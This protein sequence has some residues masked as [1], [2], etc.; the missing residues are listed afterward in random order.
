[1]TCVPIC[2]L[3]AATYFPFWYHCKGKQ[4]VFAKTA[5]PTG[6]PQAVV[7]YLYDV[8]LYPN[9]TIEQF[10]HLL[11]AIVESVCPQD[12]LDW[13]WCKQIT[14]LAAEINRLRKNKS[15]ILK[16]QI[17]IERRQIEAGSAAA[18]SALLKTDEESSRSNSTNDLVT[19]SIMSCFSALE[20][21]E[22]M[23]ASVEARMLRLVREVE[24][25]MQS[26]LK[27]MHQAAKEDN[28]KRP[29]LRDFGPT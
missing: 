12:S 22:N 16:R 20:R 28:D 9:E 29:A 10:D 21:V 15:L 26:P 13:I 18:S 19:E 25:R 4:N 1:M 6:I 11:G 8:A 3:A 27:R 7:D 24:W 17:D 14:D 2:I 23:I 5:R